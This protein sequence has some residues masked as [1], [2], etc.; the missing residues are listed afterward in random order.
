[1]F[2]ICRTDSID[3]E[4]QEKSLPEEAGWKGMRKTA[5]EKLRELTLVLRDCGVEIFEYDQK[6]DCLVL[7]DSETGEAREYP[8]VLSMIE[9]RG[10]I[11]SEDVWK[12]EEF[13]RGNLRGPLEI[14][15]LGADGQPARKLLSIVCITRN[16]GEKK[17]LLG[18][19][20]DL[21]MERR[22]EALLEEQ[23]RRD[24][25]TGL[26]NQHCG[27]KM[28][29][30]YLADKNPYDSCGLM[31][32]DIDYFKN[33]NDTFGHL[34]GD[35]VLT[36]LAGLLSVFFD[37]KDILMRA[38]GDEFVV[39]LKDISHS[40]LVHKSM[41]LVRA[42]Q[43]LTFPG[44]DYSL[45]CSVGVCFLP[46]NVSGY[47]YDQLFGNADWAL[48]QAK[49]RGRNRYVFCDNLRRFEMDLREETLTHP[50]LDARYLKND[51]IATAFEIFE[52]TA[53][54][55]AAIQILLEVI[56]IRFQLDRI[57]IIKTDIRRKSTGRQY[58]W[59]AGDI[60]LA[61]EEDGSFTREDFLTLFHSY[62]EFGTTVLQYDDM[63]MY[64]PEAAALLMQ[65]QA[66]TVVYAAMY[67][68]GRYTGAIS[69]V[70]CSDKRRWSRENRSLLGELTKIISVH[71]AKYQMTNAVQGGLSV[72]EE[73]DT[74]TGLISFNRFRE[75]TE[76][77][78]VGNENQSYV[79]VYSDFEGFKYFNQK[80]GYRNGDQLLKE[81]AEH[82]M[83]NLS[84]ET[85]TYFTRVISDHF[86]LFMP[87]PRHDIREEQIQA[88][89][90]AFVQRQ[91]QNYPGARL[92]IRTGI[93]RITPGCT[94]ASVAI[95][96]ADYARKQTG[97]DRLIRFFDE[98][99]EK[100]QR[101]ETEIMNGFDAAVSKGEFVVYLQPKFSL[102]DFSVIGAEAMVRWKWE[103]GTVLYPKDFVPLYEKSGR[104]INLDFHVF[105][106][107]AAFME[108][109]RQKGRKLYP[110]SVNASIL[111]ALEDNT[112][113]RYMEILEQHGIEPSLLE[114]ELTETATVS[115]YDDV[116]NLF[117]RL[118][119]VNMMTSL[120][121]FGAGYSILNTVIDIPV[122]TV[123]LDRA[124]IQNCEGSEKGFYFLK[125]MVSMVKGLGYHVVCEGV[126]TE[127]QVKLLKDAGCEEA[128]GYWFSRPLPM[129][130]F[131]QLVYGNETE[132]N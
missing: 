79:M 122:N 19:V 30:E 115:Y 57:T 15:C 89:N 68:E 90:E 117:Q 111:H 87:Y 23:A 55:D 103:D 7:M 100:Q 72:S 121:D 14:R 11:H 95:D 10:R 109:N 39:L 91:M 31:V 67:C 132:K 47:T 5:E 45:T 126:E 17:V 9:K 42:V 25:L 92:R 128:Q 97:A 131:E 85:Q 129:E 99:L 73:Y 58:Q 52:K 29:S 104:I 38:G 13:F 50:D 108:R 60:P 81:F 70:V 20:R 69:Y 78:I 43:R 125:Q 41:R 65:G 54:F 107:V 40:A 4:K 12:T 123:K 48:Y 120:D 62:D 33:V 24:L 74:L 82:V 51:V 37:R 76:R 102:R 118:Q 101:M 86:L 130:E 27:R 98:T 59:T 3:I 32:L 114:I 56:G 105:R 18:S 80:Y 26:Y 6:Q 77:I 44:T 28:I 93:Y 34:F 63:Q 124:F 75:E 2:F 61:L 119:R 35:K 64:S 8:G 106:Q 53:S 116:K 16:A 110:I 96:A 83:E 112:V 88:I 36:E 21:T 84:D 94:S 127:E 22:R 1:M 71:L 113:N 46:E 49:A 66:K